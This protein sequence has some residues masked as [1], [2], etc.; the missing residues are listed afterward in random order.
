MEKAGPDPEAGPVHRISPGYT[1]RRHAPG[2]TPFKSR[3]GMGVAIA[4][5]DLPGHFVS[6]P[7]HAIKRCLAA[8][9]EAHHRDRGYV[10]DKAFQA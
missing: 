5:V 1:P 3:T 9:A 7:G 6:S 10:R 4:V 2:R 8:A